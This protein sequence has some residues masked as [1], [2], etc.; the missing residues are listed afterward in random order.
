[1]SL[2]SGDS[3]AY[4]ANA[5]LMT[6]PRSRPRC[7][8]QR[9]LPSM[10]MATCFGDSAR[11]ECVYVELCGGSGKISSSVDGLRSKCS[12]YFHDLGL[13]HGKGRVDFRD[14]IVGDLLELL[15]L[16]MLLI[17]AD[18]AV[19]LEALDLV[20]GIA[21]GI[22]HGNA[23]VLGSGLALLDDLATTF[24]GGSGERQANDAGT[25]SYWA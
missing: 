10:M 25:I 12:L 9:P 6:L 4:G 11:I 16:A 1:M 18:L 8:A 5:G 24:L 21:A 2:Q 23:A 13:F 14:E 20:L 15:F 7:L 19:L 3:L 22:A 17:L